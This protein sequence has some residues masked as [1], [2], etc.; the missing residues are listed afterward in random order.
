MTYVIPTKSGRVIESG[1]CGANTK[2]IRLGEVYAFTTEDF[3]NLARYLAEHKNVKRRD[4]LAFDPQE[5]LKEEERKM[6]AFESENS[7]KKRERMYKSFISGGEGKMSWSEKK[8]IK[9]IGGKIRV[10]LDYRKK[11]I[12]IGGCRL[13]FD[14]FVDFTKYVAG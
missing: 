7:S 4:I 14:V 2:T 8:I 1:F 5:Y 11:V 12:S 9:R 10:D 13:V 3:C 6:I